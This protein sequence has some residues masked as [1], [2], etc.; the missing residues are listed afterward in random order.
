M[1]R[2]KYIQ[3]LKLISLIVGIIGGIIVIITALPKKDNS[4][5]LSGYWEMTFKVEK[6]SLDRYDNGNLEYKYRISINQK[7][8][9]IDGKGE[10]FWERFQG[11]ETFYNLDQKTPITL[12][13]NIKNNKLKVNTS[14]KG[15][16]RETTGFIEFDLTKDL[17]RIN[18]KFKTTAANSSGTAILEKINN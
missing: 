16:R 12:S 5:D 7:G 1:E 11:K 4:V 8:N 13:G 14:E 18:G 6:S 2:N 10:K 3:I 15:T 9:T 17:T